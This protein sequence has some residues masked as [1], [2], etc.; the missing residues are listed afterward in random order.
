MDQPPSPWRVVVASTASLKVTAVRR[1]LGEGFS[2]AGGHIQGVKAGSEISEQPFGHEETLRGAQNRLN[3]ARKMRP[4]A[5]LY[6]SIENGIF[7]VAVPEPRYF[8][9][10]WVVMARSG[11]ERQQVVAHSVGIEVPRQFV[12]EARA[13]GF[14]RTV[15]QKISAQ[16][17]GDAQ[18]PH[19]WLT[20]QR[21]S[22]EDLLVGA[23][24]AA[25]GQLQQLH[26]Q[27]P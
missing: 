8:D 17:G 15:G 27:R 24:T 18:D 1:L 19:R 12:D 9:V 21:C 25:W 13:E 6:V 22:R 20:A 7:E 10:A 26:P 11:D 14:D 16:H 4:D 5:D 23:L 2:A 3:N